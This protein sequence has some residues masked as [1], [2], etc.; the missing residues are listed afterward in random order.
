MYVLNVS[1]LCTRYHWW[2]IFSLFCTYTVNTRHSPIVFC[3]PT[4][5]CN[6]K[7]QYLL[8]WKLSRFMYCLLALHG[9]THIKTEY[10]FWHVA[11]SYFKI[12]GAKHDIDFAFFCGGWGLNWHLYLQGPYFSYKLRYIAGFGLVE[13]AISTTRIRTLI[14]FRIRICLI[15]HNLLNIA[16]CEHSTFWV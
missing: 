9:S 11:R 12:N 15:F 13:M 4:Q 1:D 7:R 5:L 8:D 2:W 6:A 10:V 14:F 3:S 16:P